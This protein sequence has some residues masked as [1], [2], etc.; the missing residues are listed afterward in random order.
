MSRTYV[1][2]GDGADF[3]DDEAL[4]MIR[5]LLV[6]FDDSIMSRNRFSRITKRHKSGYKFGK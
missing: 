2:M 5:D 1:E 4:L 6:D 3:A